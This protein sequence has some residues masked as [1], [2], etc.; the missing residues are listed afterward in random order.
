MTVAMRRAD[1]LDPLNLDLVAGGVVEVLAVREG[2]GADGVEQEV[3][4]SVGELLPDG[5]VL[6]AGGESEVVAGEVAL[7][8]DAVREVAK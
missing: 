8:L 5:I 3:L 1:A 7:V 4:A 2:G 6:T